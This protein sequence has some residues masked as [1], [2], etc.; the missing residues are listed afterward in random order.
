ME[1]DADKIAI[2]GQDSVHW[3]GILKACSE[4]GGT[5]WI[6]IEQE[7]YPGEKSPMECS[8]LSLQGLQKIIKDLKS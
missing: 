5:E 6:I 7:Y 8:E 3:N 4:K 2:L 1:G